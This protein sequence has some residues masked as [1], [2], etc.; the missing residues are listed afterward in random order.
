VVTALVGAGLTVRRLRED[1]EAPW[2]RW[3]HMHQT[4]RGWW[5]LPASEPRVPVLYA[6]LATR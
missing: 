1:D 4:E 2:P 3:P 6:L 5:R